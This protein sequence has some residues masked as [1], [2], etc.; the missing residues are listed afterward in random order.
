MDVNQLP[1]T[2]WHIGFVKKDEWDPRRHKARCIYHDADGICHQG[3]MGCFMR[4]CPGSAHCKYYAETES[5]AEEVHLRT[6]SVEE[7]RAEQMENFLFSG[8]AEIQHERQQPKTNAM[9]PHN[10]AE[11]ICARFAGIESIPLKEIVTTNAYRQWKPN[12]DELDKLMKFYEEHKKMDKPILVKIRDGHY[13]LEDNF[14][15]YYASLKL[16]KKW[17][18]STMDRKYLNGKKK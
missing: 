17:I 3:R 4:K 11:R 1:D 7:E 5:M 6:R 2:P 14:L 10:E 18:K 9:Q 16:R 13:T 8:Q 15:Q 12:P